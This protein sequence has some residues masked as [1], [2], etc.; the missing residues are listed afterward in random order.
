MSS[1]DL[2][3]PPLNAN[4]PATMTQI[5]RI[6]S[7]AQPYKN[8]K[9]NL[10]L[11]ISAAGSTP[12]DDWD[13][14]RL[15]LIQSH[16]IEMQIAPGHVFNER[17]DV[18]VVTNADTRGDQFEA[19]QDFIEDE[20]SLRMDIWNVN[21]YGGLFEAN[22]TEDDERANIL[23]LYQG[24]TIIFLGNRFDFYGLK[25]RSV[26]DFCDSES[27][28]E[29]CLAGTSCLF[30]G[31]VNDQAKLKNLLFP[32]SQRISDL[33]PSLAVTSWFEKD[34]DLV[35]SLSEENS[36]EDRSHQL[37][38]KKCWYRTRASSISH[39]AKRLRNAL[40]DHLP[41][42]RFW[43]CPVESVA[44]SRPGLI[45][46]LLVYRG[47]RQSSYLAATESSL[48]ADLHGQ[49]HLR[50]PGALGRAPTRVGRRRTKLDAYDQYSIV[51]AL[52]LDQRMHILWSAGVQTET[53][54][55]REDLMDLV[56]LST[57]EELV[58]EIRSF[59]RGCSWP[60]SVDL[61]AKPGQSLSAHLPGVAALLEHPAAKSS[62][63]TPPLIFNLLYFT[64]AACKAQKKRRFAKQMLLPFGHRGRQLHRALADRFE[65][66][67]TRKGTQQDALCKFHKEANSLHSNF[68]STKRNTSVLLAEDI[69]RATGKST[70][71]L[72]S[73]RVSIGDVY[74]RTR[75][76]TEGEWNSHLVLTQ[77][78]EEELSGHMQKAWDEREKLVLSEEGEADSGIGSG[79]ELS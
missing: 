34:T 31:A 72:D 74:P 65:E 43:V 10:S 42:E 70:H 55:V 11:Y 53:R 3:V 54:T 48:F 61:R 35:R 36:I 18:L 47:L 39:S 58:R 30:L 57:Q 16:D 17:A 24:K 40:Q 2:P 21:L 25:S 7:N 5:L 22:E 26:L 67:L 6:A 38:V 20:L 77:A 50:L 59:L 56:A 78:H 68:H 46:T 9:V 37:G 27:L 33:L 19:I 51:G 49:S 71:F 73:G 29:A 8:I 66:M 64:L 62:E 1:V 52:P 14:T 44:P 79:S 12:A 15:R 32:I 28:F 4:S 69:S 63:P 23:S 45:G 13:I 76:W 41:Q 60:N 75:L